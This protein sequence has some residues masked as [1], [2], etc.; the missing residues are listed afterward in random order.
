MQRDSVNKFFAG[1]VFLTSFIVYGL[2]MAPSVSFWD[3]GEFIASSYRLAIPHPPGA[4]LYLLV[5]RVFTLIPAFLMSDIA[6]RVNLISVLSSAFTVLFLY[7]CIVH[8][9]RQYLQETDGFLRYVPYAGAMIGSLVFAFSHSFW[10]NAVEAEVYAPSMFFTG[11]IVWLVFRWSERHEEIGNEKYL[12]LIAYLVGLALGVHLLNVLA[13]PMIFLIVYYRRYEMNLKSFLI[14]A[15]I[16]GLLMLLVYPVMVHRI[17]WLVSKIDFIG[18][19]FV[20][21]LMIAGLFYA[22]KNRQQIISLLLSAIL[23]I[24]IGYASYLTIY[25]R[26]GLDP[27]IDENDPETIEE[28]IK[29]MGREQYGEHHYDRERRWRE[30]DNGKNYQSASQFFW[31]YQINKMY[32]RYFLWNFAGISD[33][34]V[35]FDLSKFWLIP[36]LL[37]IGGMAYHFRRDRRHSFAVFVLFFMTGLAIILYLNQPDPQPRERDYSYV[38]SFFAFAMWVGIGAAAALE[39]LVKYTRKTS[40]GLS[41][42]LGWALTI[43]LLLAGPGRMLAVN[44]ETHDRTGNYVAWDYSYNMLVSCET[45]GV[46]FTNGDNDTFPL[47]YLQEVEGIK[48]DVRIANLSLLNT[49]WY[50][51]QLKKRPPQV[52]ISLSDERIANVNLV[53]WPEEQEFEVP[54]VKKNNWRAEANR[55]QLALDMDS[56]A[57]PASMKFK[58][59]PKLTLPTPDG[60]MVGVLRVQDLMVLNILS[61]NQFEKPLYF[62]FTT[63][64]GNQL[65]GL[66]DYMRMDGILLRITPYKDWD[67]APDRAYDLFMNKFKFRN[68]NNPDVHYDAS[69]IRLLQNYRSAYYRLADHFLKSDD[70][71]RFVKLTEKMNTAMPESV[72][73]F[74]NPTLRRVMTGLAFMAGIRPL[75]EMETDAFSL[76][77]LR[78]FG[79]MGEQYNYPRVGIPAMEKVLDVALNDP[80]NPGIEEQIRSVF[81]Q[82]SYYRQATEAEKEMVRKK[83]VIEPVRQRLVSMYEKIGE[84][85]KARDMLTQW[86]QEDPGNRFVNDNLPRI[87]KKLQEE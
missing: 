27:N 48:T 82:E 15:A 57:V 22:I 9:I 33:N 67:I 47:W 56:A 69:T 26:S 31:D 3:C 87:E 53:M 70:K 66:Q 1:F 45:G 35:D 4:P 73:P 30:S 75:E 44:Y 20:V 12:L 54:I 17:P 79:E 78:I 71:E 11:V 10:F 55:Y 37:G 52:P 24:M 65:D 77:D 43:L 21:L 50:I 59:K 16:G 62:S 38:G 76:M 83:A 63:G 81:R 64:T 19:V 8:L 72:I 40:E 23:L 46:L 85:G 36:L 60:Q 42:N 58:V 68:L 39:M 61:A 13:L 80:T 7:L 32:V 18:L 2:T 28:F 5:G 29:Y 6:S 86:K 84:T 34:K 41:N 25:I 49:S 14:F 74:N 51:E